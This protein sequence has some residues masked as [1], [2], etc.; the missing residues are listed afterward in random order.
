MLMHKKKGIQLTLQR[1][2]LDPTSK[3]NEKTLLS[4]T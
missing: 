2:C 4:E 1:A 3:T